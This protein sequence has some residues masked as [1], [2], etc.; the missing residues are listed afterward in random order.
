[1]LRLEKRGG[2][3]EGT[4]ITSPSKSNCRGHHNNRGGG[5]QWEGKRVNSVNTRES[6]ST[7]EVEASQGESKQV[8]SVNIRES[9]STTGVEA[10][11]GK[12][13]G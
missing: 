11:K 3:G 8:N 13:N 1:M 4:S 7:T 10:A 6:L 5:G 12:V 2:R 9:I